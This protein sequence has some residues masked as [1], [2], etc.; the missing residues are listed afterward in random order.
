METTTDQARQSP[1]RHHMRRN[2]RHQHDGE[3]RVRAEQGS[4]SAETNTQESEQPAMSTATK[5]RN[6]IPSVHYNP[7]RCPSCGS[8]ERG[9]LEGESQISL[10]FSGTRADGLEYNRVCWA[11]T[12]CKCG[13][14]YKV[15]WEEMR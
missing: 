9:K 6:P 2:R 8:T 13:Q 15:R 1:L 5:P 3:S 11:Y 7:P 14:R 12:T 10:E 4:S